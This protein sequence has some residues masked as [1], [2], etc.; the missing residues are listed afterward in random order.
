MVAMANQAYLS[1]WLK[2][3]PEEVMLE[4]FEQFLST[5][6]VSEKQ[7][8]FTYLEIRA[9][10][11]SESP[12]FEQD[13]RSLPLDAPSITHLAKDYLH[14]D[15]MYTARANWDLWVFEGGPSRWQKSPQPIELTCIGE[16]FDEVFWKEHGHLEANLGFEHL[17][18]GHG[19]LLGIRQIARPAQSAEEEAFLALM[20][21]PS[22]LQTY[23]EKTRENI[24]S[25]FEWERRIEEALPEGRLRLWSEG[26]ENFEARL[27]EILTAR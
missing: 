9:V 26:E 18:T 11:L 2:D 21:R 6:P 4:R 5:I 27:D 23:Q 22:N 24:Q 16:L 15:S 25:L 14:L 13:L 19:G 12:V 8:G 17:F 10:D 7:P 3:F 20:S 1:V